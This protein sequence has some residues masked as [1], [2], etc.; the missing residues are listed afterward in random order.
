MKPL[1]LLAAAA[2]ALA[3]LACSHAP[4]VVR[5]V[6]D[7]DLYLC[8]EM[9]TAQLGFIVRQDTGTTATRLTVTTRP[10]Q[11]SGQF[12]GLVIRVLGDTTRTHRWIEVQPFSGVLAR[13]AAEDLLMAGP[14]AREAAAT[15]EQRCN[16]K[17][18]GLRGGQ[19]GR[20]APPLSTR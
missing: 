9:T 20:R 12:D 4:P 1:A 5:P 14:L 8:A 2:F 7:P 11:R 17:P 13:G 10:D 18:G 6:V 16:G 3:V 15:V 19:R